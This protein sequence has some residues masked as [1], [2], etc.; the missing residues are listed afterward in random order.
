MYKI[1]SVRYES[2]I[3]KIF[4]QNFFCPPNHK[5]VPTALQTRIFQSNNYNPLPHYKLNRNHEI[6]EH[7]DQVGRSSSSAH[8]VV[9][10]HAADGLPRRGH[11]DHV[12][13]VAP[14]RVRD[15]RGADDEDTGVHDAEH[16]RGR[17]RLHQHLEVRVCLLDGRYGHRDVT[18]DGVVT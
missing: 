7:G 11:H 4:A 1:V 16:R 9:D 12:L 3:Q 2:V 13:R 14:L 5:S 10:E 8:G 6:V 18:H 17:E 15:P